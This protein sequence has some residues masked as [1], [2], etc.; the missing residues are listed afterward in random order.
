MT[1]KKLFSIGY[2][3]Y[4]IALACAYFIV[5]PQ[6]ILAPTL[7]LTLLFGVYQIYIYLI[8]PKRQLKSER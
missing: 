6:N 5:E 4:V 8:R 3:L 2:L 7:T 1:S